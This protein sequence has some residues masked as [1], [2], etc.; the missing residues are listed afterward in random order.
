MLREIPLVICFSIVS[1]PVLCFVAFPLSLTLMLMLISMAQCLWVAIFDFFFFV[2]VF[3]FWFSRFVCL[4]I[5]F[6]Q[7]LEE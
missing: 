1:S 2:V 6:D 3:A 4:V 5:G 7:V